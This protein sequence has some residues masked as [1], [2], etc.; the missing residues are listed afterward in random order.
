MSDNVAP[1]LEVVFLKAEQN[2]TNRH[3]D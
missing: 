3:D 2:M 1:L